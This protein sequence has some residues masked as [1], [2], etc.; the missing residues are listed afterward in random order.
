MARGPAWR[1]WVPAVLFLLAVAALTAG[2]ARPH[3]RGLVPQDRATVVLVLDVSRSMEARDVRPN[4]I[5]A[6]KQAI[7]LFLD[8]APERLR[9]GLV[10]FAGIPQVVSPPTRDREQVSL[11][12]EHLGEYATFGGTAI[13]DALET[14]VEVGQETLRRDAA[15]GGPGAVDGKLVSILFLSDGAQHQGI[16]Q[17]LEGAALA[18]QAG[19]RV[20]TVALG[21]PSGTVPGFD[22]GG[23][24]GGGFFEPERIPVPPDPVTLRAIA[25]ETGGEF[26]D[27]R[28]AET[29]TKAY[30]ELGSSLGR[31]EEDKEV[32]YAFI[33]GAAALLLAAGVLSSAWSSRL[34]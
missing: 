16:L 27:A 24:P 18:K 28:D 8:K 29:L 1:R 23:F 32:T 31:V 15:E 30:E 7:R 12:L 22:R 10:V 33:L 4:R 21:T 26:T 2:A 3:V 13:G 9:V 14:A 5:G 25:D 19:M 6:A 34:P 20:Y 17:P 11:S